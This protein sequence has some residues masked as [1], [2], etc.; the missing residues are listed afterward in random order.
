VQ[1]LQFPTAC[2]LKRIQGL[3]GIHAVDLKNFV[4]NSVKRVFGTMLSME[5]ESEEPPN[6]ASVTTGRHVV[7]TV[8]FAGA[9]MGNVNIFVSRD[10]AAAMTAAMLGLA[11]EDIGR[12]EDV[13]DVIGEV[14]NM[15]GGDLKSRLCDV[16]FEVESK[17]WDRHEQHGFCHRHHSVL[18]EVYIKSAN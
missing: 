8:A 17:S 13:H 10:F 14:C 2:P 11:V 4:T 7:G 15:V 16:G 18:L 12:D 1:F 9:A 5:V 6:R 3:T